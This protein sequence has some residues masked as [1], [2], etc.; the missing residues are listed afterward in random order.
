MTIKP[1]IPFL[2]ETNI[3]WLGIGK[4]AVGDRVDK[5]VR[6][7]LLRAQQVRLDKI[8]HGVVFVEVVLHRRSCQNSATQGANAR[9]CFVEISLGILQTMALVDDDNVWS[10]NEVK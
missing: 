9:H 1:Y 4:L 5:L 8:H 6:K 3:F 7:L 10:W 2:H